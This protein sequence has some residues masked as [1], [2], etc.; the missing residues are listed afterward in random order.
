MK[1][2]SLGSLYVSMA[3][4]R[5]QLKGPLT[6]K[7]KLKGQLTKKCQ[8]MRAFSTGVVWAS[9]RYLFWVVWGRLGFFWVTV[10]GDVVDYFQVC[11]YWFC[12][13]LLLTDLLWAPSSFCSTFVLSLSIS[14]K[15]GTYCRRETFVH[16]SL[17]KEEYGTYIFLRI[18]NFFWQFEIAGH[19]PFMQIMPFHEGNILMCWEDNGKAGVGFDG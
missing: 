16:W 3:Q 8:K 4:R 9:F 10:W 12:S 2:D 14:T 17:W 18:C 5:L 6:E 15:L 19:L 11:S 7:G 13:S 1:T